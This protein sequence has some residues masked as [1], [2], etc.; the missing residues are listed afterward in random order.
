[1]RLAAVLA[2]FFTLGT[3][4]AFAQWC[5]STTPPELCGP[6]IAATKLPDFD[7]NATCH[8]FYILDQKISRPAPEMFVVAEKRCVQREQVS[9]DLL[10][11]T[12]AEMPE[13]IKAW[14][15]EHNKRAPIQPYTD[16]STCLSDAISNAIAMRT[17]PFQK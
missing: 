9:Y 8:K 15:V 1:M 14:C 17:R 4:G 2:I 13:K 16:L 3:Q 7:S 12:W 5:G 10:K 6:K 11:S